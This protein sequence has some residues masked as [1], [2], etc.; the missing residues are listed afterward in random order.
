MIRKKNFFIF[1]RVLK[2]G[3]EK[4]EDWTVLLWKPRQRRISKEGKDE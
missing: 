3:N 2:R 4:V 1:Q